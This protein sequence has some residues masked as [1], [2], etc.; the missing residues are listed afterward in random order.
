MSCRHLQLDQGTLE[1]HDARSGLI[2]ASMF[3]ECA[4]RLKSGP[5]KGDYTN[6]AHAY[7]FRLAVERISGEALAVDQFDTWAMKRGRE[8]EEDARLLYEERAGA[9][10]LQTG[11]AVSECGRFGASA[12]G[13]VGINGSIEIKCFLDPTKLKS[14]LIDGDV[15][16][17]NTQMQGSLMVTGR[18]W[19]DFI[20]YCPALA[21][22][23]RDL[24]VIR[25]D[26]D[27][28]II[29]PLQESLEQFNEVVDHYRRILEQGAASE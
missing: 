15:G 14:I 18:E 3:E 16:E 25:F 27:Q 11:L 2:T 9:L 19:C 21:N 28:D 23:G 10:V 4:R 13:L 6:A 7:A 8:L 5:N 24:T 12:D 17:V 1:W 22:I 26:R 20:L 29:T